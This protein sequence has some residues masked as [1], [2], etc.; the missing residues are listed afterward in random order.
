MDGTG[1][2]FHKLG[3]AMTLADFRKVYSGKLMGNVGYTR[4]SAEEALE[5]GSADLIAFGRPFI[6]NPDLVERFEHGWP[7]AKMADMSVWYSHDA[8]GY[9]DF[10]TYEA[11]SSED[12]VEQPE[13][14][15]AE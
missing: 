3:P 12:I 9:T 5:N 1:F 4:E 7:L 6:S 11:A 8:H 10:P 14:C 13:A 2:G 15:N